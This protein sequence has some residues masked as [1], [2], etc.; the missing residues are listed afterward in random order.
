M[1]KEEI[2]QLSINFSDRCHGCREHANNGK[3]NDYYVSDNDGYS[4]RFDENNNKR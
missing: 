3:T 2:G 1:S 4:S